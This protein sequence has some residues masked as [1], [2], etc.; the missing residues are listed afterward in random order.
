MTGRPRQIVFAF[1][2]VVL[3]IIVAGATIEIG[4]RLRSYR[5]WEVGV[6][7]PRVPIMFE[8]DPTLGWRP[9]PGTY[10]IPPY[11]WS[12]PVHV[13]IRAD[14]SRNTG[15]PPVERPSL[16]FV[17][18]SF[19]FGWGVSDEQT[20]AARLQ[21]K[22]PDWNVMNNGV[23]AYGTYQSLLRL[24]QLLAQGLKPT[25]VLYGYMQGHE[26]R[27][28][29][30][31]YWLLLL[32]SHSTQGMVSVPYA[33]LGGGGEL[34]RHPPER[35]PGWPLRGYLASVSL[36]ERDWA[37]LARAERIEKWQEITDRILLDMAQLC[38]A[39]GIDF[40]VVLL[41]AQPLSKDHYARLLGSHN[42]RLIDCAL[43]RTLD[44][45]IPHDGH[46]NAR[47][48][49]MYADCIDRGLNTS[50]MD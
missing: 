14:H 38:R 4:L 8:A 6:V 23:P 50:P 22:H 21:Q 34:L 28:V 49:A 42:I 31:P 47:A 41:E 24:D 9:K 15:A 12:G 39:N 29:A 7:D 30:H 13:M 16:A 20:F 27:N 46:P 17:G 2:A 26:L 35:A 19:T 10:T 25:R 33:T 5:P 32:E 3:G 48:H 11:D 43:P 45:T 44:L 1:L 36:L 37:M 40:A 18:C